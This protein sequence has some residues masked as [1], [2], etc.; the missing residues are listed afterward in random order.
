MPT[1][2]DPKKPVKAVAAAVGVVSTWL[3]AALADGVI[4]G[5]EWG[6]VALGLVVTVAAVFGLK[7]P[8]VEE[9]P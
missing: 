1:K 7:N 9:T 4:T 2:A 6:A 8:Q 3:V 5:Q